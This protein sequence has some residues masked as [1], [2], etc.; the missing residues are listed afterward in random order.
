MITPNKPTFFSVIKEVGGPKRIFRWLLVVTLTW[1]IPAIIFWTSLQLFINDRINRNSSR[2]FE[3]IETN[4]DNYL[5]E[6]LPS[7]F[8]RP[9]FG[10]LFRQIKGIPANNDFLE[11]ILAGFKKQWPENMLEI[12]LFNGDSSIMTIQGAREEH[13]IFFRQVNSTYDSGQVTIEQLNKAGMLLPAPDMMISRVRDQ[14]DKVIEL[15]NPDRFSYCYF[16][17]DQSVKNRCVAGILVFVHKKHMRLEEILNQTVVLKDP[18]HYGYIGD[19]A[20]K[21][22]K[23]LGDLNSTQILDYFQ[24]YP[25][26]S[27]ELNGKLIGVKRLDEYTLLLGAFDRPE[28]P[29]LIIAIVSLL[30]LIFSIFFI[31]LCYRVS[32]LQMRFQHNIR[33]RLIG[34]FAICYALPLLAA[35]FL[36][37]QYLRELKHAMILDE[38]QSNYRRLA[39]LD[40]GFTRFVT[41]RLLDFRKFS[42]E[43]QK[44]ITNPQLLKTRL[45]EKYENFTADSLHMVSSQSVVIYSDDLLTAEVRR[46]FKKSREEQQKVLDSWKSRHASISDRHMRALFSSGNTDKTP[47]TP[48]KSDGHESFV[49]LFASTGLAAMDYYN[50]S[51]DIV[52]PLKRTSSNLV[53]DTI[54]ESNTQTL[55]QS[56]RTNISRFTSIQSLEES[57]LAYLDVLPGPGGEA[58]YAFA[59]LIDL[60][61]FERSYFEKLFSGLMWRNE[62]MN[63]VFPEEDIRAVSTHPYAANFP[64]VLEFKNFEAIIR[65]SNSDCKTFSQQMKIDGRDC[66]VSVLRG[67]YL[68]HYLLLKITPL[69]EFENIFK[70]RL[71]VVILIFAVILI[72]GLALARLLTRLLILPINDIMMGVK[73]LAERNYQHRITIRS[74]NEFGVLA[75]AFNDS[76]EILKRLAISEKIR[77][78]LYPEAEFRCGSYLIATANSNSR[79]ILSDFFDYFPL[80]QGTYAIILAEVSGNDISAAY[81]TAMLKTSFTLL[82]PSFPMR[83]DTIL[84]K[85]NQIFLPYYQRGHLTT[86]FVGIIDPT[87][88]LMICSNAGQSYPICVS[89][90]LNEKFFVSLPSTPLGLSADT[91]FKNHEI[92]LENRVLVLHSD[93][94]VNLLD[95]NGERLGHEQFLELV[96]KGLSTDP[97]NPAEE[98]LKRL[99]E[100]AM[101]VPWRDDITILTIQNRI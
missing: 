97:R 32:V 23:I 72:M 3:Q 39:E 75:R 71:H 60:V 41:A 8:F 52:I 99:N 28:Y 90:K 38:K 53:I 83:P 88:D 29:G 74:E 80:K 7:R 48:D 11:K 4:L 26:N 20:E 18:T 66:L 73:A 56:A 30:F 2:I 31:R 34:L 19:S 82:C 14:R 55:F 61:N 95:R 44:E 22:P 50:R 59:M 57:F 1:G 84:D 49:K 45:K 98:I 67:S 92:K 69:D 86:C 10:D 51:N 76:A 100:K 65:R 64:S 9:Q 25:T 85:L 43:L 62:I 21:L 42:A 70:Q 37:F 33:H 5:Y 79:I 101:S 58:W 15:G 35:S 13:E 96:V 68:R 27:F 54:I 46:H 12:Y 24:Q 47:E 40:A 6:S 78:Q 81:L 16:D 93:G 36:M 89:D 94:A 63:R 77:K 17:F 91:K 87:N